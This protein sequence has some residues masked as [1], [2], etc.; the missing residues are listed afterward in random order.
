MT[1][2]QSDFSAVQL[3]F[4]SLEPLV[5]VK[6]PKAPIDDRFAA[7]H[8]ANPHVY[9]ALKNLALFY[10]RTMGFD[11]MG[12]KALWER[13]RFGYIETTGDDGYKLNNDFTACY[14]RLLMAN[15]PELE[16]FFEL[17]ERKSGKEVI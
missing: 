3:I 12:M 2:I 5:A 15:E 13:L 14:A 9:T 4:S 10:K 17:R 7:F 8:R 16:G 11:R 1:Q 6:F